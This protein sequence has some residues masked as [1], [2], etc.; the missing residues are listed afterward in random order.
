MGPLG[1]L[2][3]NLEKIRTGDSSDELDLF[4]CL[5]LVE[6]SV[7]LLGQAN[8]SLTYARRLSI[9]GRLTGDM[10]KAKK[11]LNKHES[12]LSSSTRT[13]LVKG[14]TRLFL[15]PPRFGSPPRTFPTTYQALLSHSGLQLTKLPLFAR[16]ASVDEARE[17]PISPFEGCPHHMAGVGADLSLSG[18]GCPPDPLTKA[19]QLDS[20]S[21]GDHLMPKVPL[22]VQSCQGES[23]QSVHPLL[24]SMGLNTTLVTQNLPLAGRLH[25]F[26]NNWRLL[27]QDQFILKMIEGVLIPFVVPPRQ[28]QPPSQTFHNQLE[29]HA[30][31]QEIAEML[32]KRAIQVVSPL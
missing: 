31:E 18:Q 16:I 32:Q 26:L 28:S 17:T 10:K 6:Q 11:L 13:C 3:L 9:L 25:H 7:T 29:R 19:S 27:T 4:D 14:F 12:S 5:K 2:W 15:R 1:K 21:K 24:L 23:I 8:V 22:K 20:G 30:I